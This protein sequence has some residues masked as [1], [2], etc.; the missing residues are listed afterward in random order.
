MLQ[1]IEDVFEPGKIL[2]HGVTKRLVGIEHV[3][4]HLLLVAGGAIGFIALEQLALR[5][6]ASVRVDVE[7]LIEPETG[8]KVSAALAA[9][10]HMEMSVSEFLQPQR[11]PG[12]G[13]HERGIHHGAVLEVDHELTVTAVDHLT[14]KLLEVAAVEE[15]SLALD[16][17]PNGFAVYPD[18][19]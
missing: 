9:M 19:D 11:D 14:G 2:G 12:H 7:N 3:R 10:D 5:G 8:K 18:L 15:A 17:H 13:S 1:V 4:V 16:L 6:R